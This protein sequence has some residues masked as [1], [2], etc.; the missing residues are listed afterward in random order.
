LTLLTYLDSDDGTKSVVFEAFET[1]A[2][3]ETVLASEGAL[4]WD[5]PGQAVLVPH[6]TFSSEDFQENLSVFLEQASMES[7]KRFAAVTYK[8]CA[9]LPEIRDTPDPALI[10]G[11]LMTILEV[12]GAVHTTPLLRKR[13]R[14]TVSFNNARKP[15][16]RSALY[17]VL[18]V[19]IQRHLYTLIGPEKGRLY[20]KTIMCI[21][22]SRLLDDGLFL[23]SNEASNSLRQKLGRRL[24]KLEV[25]QAR[26]GKTYN[27]L[28]RRL[29]GPL[30]RI[31]EHS[32]VSAGRVIE[33]EW[34]AFKR[35]TSRKICLIQPTA[36][37]FD[38][39][40]RLLR[41]RP[42]LV[43]AMNLRFST[44]QSEIRSPSELLGQYHSHTALKPFNA[45]MYQHLSL[46]QYEDKFSDVSRFSDD[47]SDTVS[48]TNYARKIEDYIS[49][50]QDAYTDYPELKS[51]QLLKIMELWMFM[52]EHALKCYPLLGQYHPCFEASM[53]DKL[54]LSTIEELERLRTVQSYV[55]RRCRGWFG[56]GSKTIF[57][58]PAVDSFAVRYYD[59][60][61]DASELHDLH[62]EIEKDADELVATKKS[63]WER[64]S[65]QHDFKMR[66]VAELSCLYTTET[67][68]HGYSR[69]V[70]KKGCLKHKLKWEATQILIE[71]FEYPLPKNEPSL[72]A[73]IFELMCPEAFAAYRDATWLILSTFAYRDVEIIEDVPLVRVY[74]GLLSYANKTISKVTLGSSTKS[75]LDTHYATIGFPNDFVDVCL[76]L[77]LKLNYYHNGTKAWTRSEE[78]P[79]FAHLFPLKL[80]SDSPYHSFESVSDNWPTSNR[81]LATQTRCPVDLNVHEY[82]AWQGLLVGTFSRWP[83]LLREMGSTNLSF[84]TE[85]T[86]AI[87]TK[88]LSQAGPS[89]SED[90]LRDVH[91][92]FHD[93]NFCRELLAQVDYRLEAIRRNWREP[94][95]L[96]ILLSI[97]IKIITLTS[98]LKVRAKATTLLAK[99][100][101]I[102]KGWGA[103]LTVADQE[104]SHSTLVF[105]VWAAVLC[106][107]T[108]Y[109]AFDIDN[110]IASE[111]LNEFVVASIALQNCLVGAFDTLPHSLRNAVLRD[112]RLAYTCRDHLQTALRDDEGAMMMA[113]GAYWPI[114]PDCMEVPVIT[115]V[116]QETWWV[117]LTLSTRYGLQHHVHYNFVQGT[118]LINGQELGTLPPEY[119]HWP[120]I[121]ELFGA[122]PLKIFPSPL[123]GMSLVISRQ[124]PFGHWVHL[125]FR[126][127]NIVI[128]AEHQGTILELVKRDLFGNERQYDLPAPLG[129]N[130]YHWLNLST[131]V[132][133]IRQ[134]DPWK[135]KPGNWRLDLTTRRATRNNG[136]TLVDPSSDLAKKIAQNFY[137]FELPHHITVYQTPHGE[138]RVELKRLELDFVVWKTGLLYCPQLGAVI[139]ETR[140]QDVGTWH[141]LK[142]KLI[143][144]SPKDHTQRS[145]LLPMGELTCER[146]GPHVS[147]VIKNVGGYLKFGINPVLGRVECPAE[148]VLL[149]YRAFWHAS[150]AYFL[151]DALTGRTGVEEALRYLQSGAYHPW[152]PLSESACLVLQALTAL[153]PQ[154]AYYPTTLKAMESVLWNADYTVFL[155][156]DRYRRV[157]D[158]ILK[159]NSE[160]S[161]FA[162]AVTA[163]EPV[164]IVLGN[165]HLEN[166]ALYRSGF[167]PS[168]H[169][170]IYKTRDRRSDGVECANVAVVAKLLSDRPAQICNTTQLMALL[171]EEP[172]IGGYVRSFNKIQMTDILS[173]EL[174]IE[175]GALVNTALECS[176]KFQLTFLFSLLAFS[177][178][179]NMDILRAIISFSLISDLK[180]I[181]YP[182]AG[183][184][185]HFRGN[186]ACEVGAIT[187]LLAPARKPY[188][189]EGSIPIHQL[190]MRQSDHEKQVA[191]ACKIFA[192][193]IRA[194]W[195]SDELDLD[196]LAPVASK[197]LDRDEALLY[198]LPEWRRLI[199][200]SLMAKHVEEVQLVLLRHSANAQL[201]TSR[202]ALRESPRTHLYPLRMRGGEVPNIQDILQKDLSALARSAAVEQLLDTA[203][204]TVLTQ[205]PNGPRSSVESASRIHA[206]PDNEKRKQVPVPPPIYEL[207]KLISPYKSSS[208][209]IHKR[210]G[211]ELE[212]S[213]HALSEHLAKPPVTQETFNPAKLSSDVSRAREAVRIQSDRIRGALMKADSRTRWLESVDLWPNMTLTTLL[214]ELRSTSG[215]RFGAGVKETLVNLGLAVT[216][217]QRLLRIQDAVQRERRQ[218][219]LDERENVGHTNWSPME[220]VDWLLLEIDSDILL[221]AE[222]VDVA[223]ATIS[224]ES[225]QNSVVQ[226]LMGKGKTSCILRK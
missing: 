190:F 19:A 63:E 179:V 147:I 155:Q 172:I 124:M 56:S 133:E 86:W 105:I 184:Y 136:S 182:Q 150:T 94:V 142:S 49:T 220:R 132:I 211:A 77:G 109:T 194:Q 75:H 139:A 180:T 166:R 51:Q 83:N 48:C 144:R 10:T 30:R 216:K 97:L 174:G 1:S 196:R 140:L 25:D 96:D 40:L 90:T 223:V 199:D 188:F 44:A 26:S 29:Y 224:P 222:Q 198:V 177:S 187:R 14:D 195:P 123:Q 219:I 213:V 176:Q 117:H 191:K 226:L 41:S 69:Q 112:L 178:N 15:W 18:R 72:K 4:Q 145:I 82:M 202:V 100:R 28:H 203:P 167:N 13:V 201:G 89:E 106:K 111:T 164:P 115:H 35:R 193:S 62:Q 70:H 78:E 98:S 71:I 39:N 205:L 108:F 185:S 221:R 157:V 103:S 160:L 6:D 148:P 151:P 192:E 128:R 22:M 168:V 85:S 169:D 3:C 122:Q 11:A 81:V 156:D 206:H 204:P 210:Y 134:H 7:I 59:N 197:L 99:A 32:L 137:H 158:D 21:L 38:L 161:Q 45:V 125:G 47:R 58:S 173:T 186:E 200:N 46:H 218:Q 53:L 52:D 66:E 207:Q 43:R 138:I 8:A 24:A 9:P 57:D 162:P 74:S 64:K 165:M 87:V 5:F 152:T 113:L 159:R 175:W 95:Q 127:N 104:S 76:L 79:S 119:R 102:T 65:E 143:V 212:H 2:T 215:V 27:R 80:P 93:R 84:S 126:D 50:V 107:R 146:E 88:V 170:Q 34:E 118:L 91:S 55:A 17:L 225:G 54:E 92:V 131:G 12:N 129:A 73:V 209:M 23:I 36:S 121:E 171:E 214:S 31:M 114:P 116:D 20:Y 16:R 153:S 149:Y 60:S 33:S 163:A 42:A 120:I 208:S 217:Y 37:P 67:D 61:Q 130:C 110:E 141:G 189:T 183:A 68:E 101:S 135:S 154:R 181:S